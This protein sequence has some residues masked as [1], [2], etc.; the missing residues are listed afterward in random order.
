[1][2]AMAAVM[3]IVAVEQQEEEEEEEEEEEGCFSLFL[4]IT[5]GR[6]LKLTPA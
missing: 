4:I 6:G 1:M 2:I 3:E 5:S